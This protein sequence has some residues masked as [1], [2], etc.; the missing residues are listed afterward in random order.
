MQI[1]HAQRTF[2]EKNKRWAAKLEDLML[3]DSAGLPQHTTSL[4]PTADGYEAAITFTPPGGMPQTW[5][6]RQDSRISH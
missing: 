4:R 5:T 6:I 3:P 2:H 1:Y